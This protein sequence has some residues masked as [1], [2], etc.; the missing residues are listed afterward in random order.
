MTLERLVLHEAA[1]RKRMIVVLTFLTADCEKEEVGPVWSPVEP[2]QINRKLSGS[3]PA[4]MHR[5][6]AALTPPS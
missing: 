5:P 4:E 2:Q 1:V 3:E 6:S